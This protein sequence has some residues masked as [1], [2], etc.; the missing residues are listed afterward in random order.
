M[1]NPQRIFTLMAVLLTLG[2]F[3]QDAHS[4]LRVTPPGLTQNLGAVRPTPRPIPRVPMPKPKS[5]GGQDGL[6]SLAPNPAT[7]YPNETALDLQSFESMREAIDAGLYSESD[8]A[9]FDRLHKEYKD[10]CKQELGKIRTNEMSK[11]EICALLAKFQNRDQ[12]C[13]HLRQNSLR[14]FP[15]IHPVAHGGAIHQRRKAME[16]AT[17]MARKYCGLGN[18][19]ISWQVPHLEKLVANR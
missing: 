1:R 14:R 5:G 16:N 8:Y 11:E 12:R 3:Q 4:F 18:S 6:D 10:V 13:A 2:Y 9:E 15:E 19:N 7:D 17:K